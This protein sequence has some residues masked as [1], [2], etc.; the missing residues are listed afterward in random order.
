MLVISYLTPSMTLTLLTITLLTMDN[1]TGRMGP[2]H[3]SNLDIEDT[4]LM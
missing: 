4:T 2:N 3:G 1:P